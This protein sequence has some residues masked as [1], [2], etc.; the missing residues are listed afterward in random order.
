MRTAYGKRG[1]LARVVLLMV[2]TA[3]ILA[4]IASLPAASAF[5]DTA[6]LLAFT[7]RRDMLLADGEQQ[8]PVTKRGASPAVTPIEVVK[9]LTRRRKALCALDK[10][11]IVEVDG[12][13][14][15]S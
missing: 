8:V 14:A 13:S 5:S 12:V 11:A 6:P 9:S 15:S 7:S 2:A 1:P 4:A 10:I 3:A